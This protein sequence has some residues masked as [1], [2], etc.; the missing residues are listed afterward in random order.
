MV[1][2][3][4]GGG[5][6]HSSYLDDGAL[7]E[8]RIRALHGLGPDCG[9]GFRVSFVALPILRNLVSFCGRVIEEKRK[10]D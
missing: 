2:G 4:S 7:N 3:G 8:Y 10:W 9:V 5:L 1:V 6:G